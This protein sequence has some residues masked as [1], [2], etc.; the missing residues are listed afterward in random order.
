MRIGN[1][2]AEIV[3]YARHQRVDLIMMPTRGATRFRHLLLGS[4]TAAVLHDA[5]CSVWT[6]AHA[7]TIQPHQ[8]YRSILCAVDLGDSTVPVLR[9]ANLFA[10]RYGAGL[11][12]V[13]VVAGG[14]G[15]STTA[16]ADEA[17]IRYATM[18]G[19]AGLPP[20]TAMDIVE[21]RGVVD[22]ITEAEERYGADLLVI[23]RGRMQGPL[24]RLRTNCHEL[25]RLSKCAVLSV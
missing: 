3:E 20:D 4:V 1:P 12:I 13:H 10:T 6:T 22:A 2:T 19:E 23:G 16:L 8:P 7:E 9:M 21:S 18:A 15:L 14:I 25:I 11:R 24:G 5:E 17:L